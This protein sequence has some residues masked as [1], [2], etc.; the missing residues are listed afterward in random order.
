[1]VSCVPGCAADILMY[2]LDTI[3]SHFLISNS[4]SRLGDFRQRHID[5]LN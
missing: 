1:M 4:L 5:E 3:L 2:A